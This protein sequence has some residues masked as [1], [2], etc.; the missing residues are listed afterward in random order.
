MNGRLSTIRT[1]VEKGAGHGGRILRVARDT[2][3]TVDGWESSVNAARH[4]AVSP[5]KM[6][7]ARQGAAVSAGRTVSP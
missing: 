6:S 5:G 2:P 1:E 3:R 4:I 7:L